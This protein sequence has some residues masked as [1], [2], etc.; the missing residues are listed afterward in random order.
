MFRRYNFM[1]V[2]LDVPAEERKVKDKSQPVAVDEEQEGQEAVN[3]SLGDDV[4]VE[5]V[6]K[7]DRVDVVTATS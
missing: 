5:T 3:G 6:A 2:L 1:D 4:C 7:I